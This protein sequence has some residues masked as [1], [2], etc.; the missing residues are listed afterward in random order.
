MMDEVM[1]TLTQYVNRSTRLGSIL[2][3]QEN[4]IEI[5]L[6]LILY[7]AKGD[8]VVKDLMQHTTAPVC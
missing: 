6:L 5:I 3:D 4:G 2:Q 7:T 8:Y 1:L